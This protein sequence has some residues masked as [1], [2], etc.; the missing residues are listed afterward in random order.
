M[1]GTTTTFQVAAN[2]NLNPQTVSITFFENMSPLEIALRAAVSDGSSMD[3]ALVR[4]PDLR[5]YQADMTARLEADIYFT[6]AFEVVFPDAL[7]NED[8]DFQATYVGNGVTRQTNLHKSDTLVREAEL[9]IGSSDENPATTILVGEARGESDEYQVFAFD[10]DNDSPVDGKVSALAIRVDYSEPYDDISDLIGHAVLTTPGGDVAGVVEGGEIRFSDLKDVIQGDTSATMSLKIALAGDISEGGLSFT[11]DST[12]VIATGNDDNDIATVSGEAHSATHT[13]GKQSI[14]V[15]PV[16]TLARVETLNTVS[17]S[18]GEYTIKFKVTAL[19]DD[20]YISTT[21]DANTAADEGVAFTIT[22]SGTFTGT[23]TQLLTS[24]AD[25]SGGF[26]VVDEGSSETFTLTVTLDPA[27]S[28]IFEVDLSTIT[29]N[30]AASYVTPSIFTVDA[31]DEDF[32]TDP[33][34]IPS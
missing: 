21:T 19:D 32:Q 18:Y 8:M 10:I 29:F 30:E 20:A 31:D 14:V 15:I 12:D 16:S 9:A 1:T 5:T 28:G 3:I 17:S 33:V 22:G 6:G 2:Q 24:T 27:A 4:Q 23:S 34:N 13:V 11:L 25:V 26:F 7:L